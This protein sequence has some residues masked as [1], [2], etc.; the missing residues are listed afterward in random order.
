[1]A[2]HL[3]MPKISRTL[4]STHKKKILPFYV[5]IPPPR[6]ASRPWYAE[7]GG[8]QEIFAGGH[9]KSN[10]VFGTLKM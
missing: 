7:A 5:Q 2:P 4:F 10:V 8:M 9:R 1:M 3:D 6:V